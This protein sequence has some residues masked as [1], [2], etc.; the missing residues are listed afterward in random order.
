VKK[1]LALLISALIILLSACQQT[2]TPAPATQP[3]FTATL[4]KTPTAPPTPTDT[5]TLTITVT[6]SRTPI[7]TKTPTSTPT[8]TQTPNP[9][10]LAGL[11]VISVE[12]AEGLVPLR[13]L[14]AHSSLFIEDL[15]FS[16]DGKMLASAG[17]TEGIKVWDVATGAEVFRF[18]DQYNG[19]EGVSFSPDGKLLATRTGAYLTNLF[20]IST[21]QVIH[22]LDGETTYSGGVAI[23]P[24]GKFLATA[25]AENT[26]NLWNIETWELALTLSGHT[27]WVA[28]LIFSADGQILVSD[29]FDYMIR[30]WNIAN[31]QEIQSFSGTLLALSPDGRT[32]ATT[33]S[34][35]PVTLWDARTGREIRTLS[36][37]SILAG[38]LAFSPDGSLLASGNADR[39]ITLWDASTGQEL[40]AVSGFS[41][42][43]SKVV[44]SQDG[45]LLASASD[46]GRIT[47]LG[48]PSDSDSQSPYE[49]P[50]TPTPTA[51]L[52]LISQLQTQCLAG[53]AGLPEN[54]SP[55]GRIVLDSKVTLGNGR[56]NRDSFLLDV[57]TCVATRINLAN[58]G[59]KDFSVSPDRT[60]LAYQRTLLDAHDN[61]VG[62]ELVIA[63]KSGEELISLPWEDEWLQIV[64]WLDNQRVVINLFKR[65]EN[66]AQMYCTL[67]VLNPFTGEHQILI[68]DFAKMYE[69]SPFPDWDHWGVTMYDPTLTRVVYLTENSEFSYALWDLQAGKRL[70]ILPAV[71][72]FTPQWS[73]DGS[74]FVIEAF[75]DEQ[76]ALELYLVN[77]DGEIEQITNLYG[78]DETVLTNY[79]WSP[80]G[81]YIAAWLST[82]SMSKDNEVELVI[83]DTT[84][85]EIKHYDVQIK[86]GGGFSSEPP[87]KPIWSSDGR[88]LII[89]EWFEQ[90][91]RQIFLIDVLENVS[92]S[93]AKDM[94][95]MGWM[96]A[97]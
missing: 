6:P 8:P 90:D 80:D 68:P 26:I 36:E 48:I 93:I 78:E 64:D 81:R 94:E 16:P 49:F 89:E 56:S 50:A 23:S 79:S 32:I 4:T 86:H 1:L 60:L 82:K 71:G 66:L 83:L 70:A 96:V 22:T 88:Y 97:P 57:G 58:E 30:V 40:R 27:D 38:D 39:T 20:D 67:L 11:E 65:Q 24:D 74:R 59:G 19:A 41:D 69:Y 95:P 44:F 37:L 12:N 13:G 91:H 47:I 61:M 31:G 54:A 14:Y 35:K 62:E 9:I 72:F 53:R 28:N 29:D 85:Y 87:Q 17:F 10:N 25:G 92:V 34:Q 63:D 52:D 5:L 77:R 18:V 55:N 73:P 15:E 42:S 7:P 21:W 3:S 76:F 84:T 2:R 75:N 33:S 43:V 46:D 51:T 45:R